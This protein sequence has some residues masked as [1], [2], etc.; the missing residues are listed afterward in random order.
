MFLRSAKS[1]SVTTEDDSENNSITYGSNDNEQTLP[2]SVCNSDLDSEPTIIRCDS[3]ECKTLFHPSCLGDE[4][5]LDNEKW[6]C[7][8]CQKEG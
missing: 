3:A 6:I 4:A 8:R 7:P 2:C 1:D 5:P